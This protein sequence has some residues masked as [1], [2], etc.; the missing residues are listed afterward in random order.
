MEAAMDDF[1]T[2]DQLAY[3]HALE[4]HARAHRRALLARAHFAGAL[5]GADLT[6][7]Q[8]ARAL[9]AL[10]PAPPAALPDPEAIRAARRAG[11]GAAPGS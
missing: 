10:V 7:E 6:A 8:R 11:V 9:D 2:G 1:D 4:G 5:A 3:W